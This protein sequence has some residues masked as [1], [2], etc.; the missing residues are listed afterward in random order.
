[1]TGAHRAP[2]QPVGRRAGGE[3]Q[4]ERDR[5]LDAVVDVQAHR[6]ERLDDLDRTGPTANVC[7]SSPAAR[8]WR[9]I[10]GVAADHAEL[11]GVELAARREVG[12]RQ[13]HDVAEAVAAGA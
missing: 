13:D 5:H 7:G 2:P 6:A 11:Q 3:R 1:M 8:A 12:H 10:V 4:V 9:A